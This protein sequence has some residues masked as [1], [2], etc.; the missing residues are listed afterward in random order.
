MIGVTADA[1]R[2]NSNIPL[3]ETE[4][5]RRYLLILND[6]T[7]F[8]PEESDAIDSLLQVHEGFVQQFSDINECVDFLTD[9]DGSTERAIVILSN[10]IVSNTFTWLKSIPQLHGIEVYG[11]DELDLSLIEQC[12]GKLRKRTWKN[13]QSLYE[14]IRNNTKEE[15]DTFSPV[16]FIS[17]TDLQND[18][19]QD[20]SFMYNRLIMDIILRN[21][22]ADPED[23]AR[24][25]M[26]KFCRTYYADSPSDLKMVDEFESEYSNS[27]AIYWYS[28]ECFVH[29]LV[30]KALWDSEPDTL[31]FIRYFLRHLDRSIYFQ[32]LIQSLF[33]Q[34][35]TVYRGQ[36]MSM[37]DINRLKNGIGGLLSF[38]GF[39]STS[40]DDN[41]ALQYAEPFKYLKGSTSIVFMIDIDPQKQRCP[42]I[43]VGRMSYYGGGEQE[44]LFKMG[45]VFRI[46][47][48]ENIDENQWKIHLTSTDDIDKNLEKYTEKMQRQIISDHPMT[49]LVRL[50]DQFRQYKL[51]N[52]LAKIFNEYGIGCKAPLVLARVQH[53]IGS[54]YVSIDDSNKAIEYLGA[55]LQTYTQYVAEDDKILS[56]TYNNLGSAYLARKDYEVSLMYHK[57]AINCQTS[58]SDQNFDSTSVYC[59]N[60]AS[61]YT[62]MENYVEAMRYQKLAIKYWKQHQGEHDMELSDL[63][64]A[65]GWTCLKQGDFQEASKLFFIIVYSLKIIILL[66]SYVSS[67]SSRS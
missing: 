65:L 60:T 37:K 46:Q 12:H 6:D 50:A 20:P 40:L 13:L 31:Y 8:S 33:R 15:M 28:R 16:S 59:M 4:D 61:V 19:R 3:P 53:V 29:K 21:Y 34:P 67:R 30:N 7:T 2:Q 41:V 45:S 32:A 9:L 18:N 17:A 22:P 51:V 48:I 55:A 58:S 10:C 25:Q 56:S 26:I 36:G 44:I 27:K 14:F 5:F 49:G 35:M 39:L 57:L 24:S 38:R 1:D 54:A 64:Q 42:F 63:Y 62:A 43:E 11:I 47:E 52:K 23:E 66:L